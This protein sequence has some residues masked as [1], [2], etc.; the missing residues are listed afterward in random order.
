MSANI[1]ILEATGRGYPSVTYSDVSDVSSID[2][3]ALRRSYKQA[4]REYEDAR[5]NYEQNPS[6]RKATKAL[7]GAEL[8]K[9]AALARLDLS[10]EALRRI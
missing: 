1:V 2:M 9:A 3:I 5:Y 4:C 6:S 7:R 8:N 10:R